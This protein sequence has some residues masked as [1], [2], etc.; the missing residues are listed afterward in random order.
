MLNK[1]IEYAE[2][3][4]S[5]IPIRPRGKKPIITWEQYQKRQATQEEIEGWFKKWPEMNIGIVTGD[6][7]KL[8]VVDLDSKEA[9][10]WANSNLPRPV[11]Y[12]KTARGFQYFYKPNGR[13]IPL[14]ADMIAGVK[15]VDCRG[16]GGYIVAAPS[17]HPTGV[18][19]EIVFLYGGWEDL[20]EFPYAAFPPKNH[21]DKKPC[22][23]EPV[24]EGARDSSL[25]RI[26]G[27]YFANGME[28]PE[29]L[30]MCRGVNVS[31][32]PPLEDKEVIKI[33]DSIWKREQKKTGG[34]DDNDD[35][36]DTCSHFVSHDDSMMTMM[37][38]SECND[39]NIGQINPK[40]WGS[41]AGNINYYVQKNV[42]TFTNTDIDREF[43][44][45]TRREKQARS[46][47][48]SRLQNDKKIE[49]IGALWRIVNN[50]EIKVDF[51]QAT[52]EPLT[53]PFPLGIGDLAMFY[54]GSIII[55]SGTTNAGKTG[56]IM[57]TITNLLS[58]ARA[59]S[60]FTLLEKNKIK[61]LNSEMVPDEILDWEETLN[62][63]LHQHVDFVYRHADYQDVINP[64]GINIID[65]LEIYQDF[66]NVGAIIDSIFKRLNQ[67][68][69]II[70]LQKRAG[71]DFALG[72]QFSQWKARLVI[73]LESV[74]NAKIATLVKVKKPVDKNNH[75]E[76]KQCDYV[77]SS[78]SGGFR[79][80][81]DW[82][83]VTKKEREQLNNRYASQGVQLPKKETA[84]YTYQFKR[85][86][87]SYANVTDETVKKWSQNMA[88]INVPAEL[89]R[90][91][92][93]SE[94][95]PFLKCDGWYMQIV[96]ILGK[97]N[98]GWVNNGKNKSSR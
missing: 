56:F 19:Y 83:F 81:T 89:A 4:L 72:G 26:A 55:I 61:Y 10:K 33:V 9:L 45:S 21:T 84:I 22:T 71:A 98:E 5:V 87:G 15:G 41:I 8:G 31:Y 97:K 28:Y 12:Q 43:C 51:L 32:Q 90:I 38:D 59:N 6:I 79:P 64:D 96:G 23:I 91:Q 37:T 46:I 85:V 7:S 35:N 25:T 29:V 66:Y 47:A 63:P 80:I 92:E 50:E 54:P 27:K 17:I 13:P 34:N 58:R 94:R 11:A 1:A 3:G 16:E 60:T 70:A 48:L 53:L 93:D 57:Q 65:F 82:R 68:I 40:R 73:N 42:G 14:G 36:D 18:I 78:S 2:Y 20:T 24:C 39:D 88:N 77:I 52:G 76:G 75:P 44:L 74:T 86:D 67:G 95:R 30:A 62:F 69:A 49:K